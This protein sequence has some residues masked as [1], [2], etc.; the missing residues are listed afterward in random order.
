M[1][2]MFSL[3][4]SLMKCFIFSMVFNEIFSD[5]IGLSFAYVRLIVNA[6]SVF[7]WGFSIF[8][9]KLFIKMRPVLDGKFIADFAGGQIGLFQKICDPCHCER[10]FIL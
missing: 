6:L 1:K 2:S 3:W 5:N 4:I 9:F 8:F 10:I 7:V